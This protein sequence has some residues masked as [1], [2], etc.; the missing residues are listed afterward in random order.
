MAKSIHDE[1]EDSRR[2]AEQLAQVL[3]DHPTAEFIGLHG[4]RLLVASSVDPTHV[5]L[6]TANGPAQLLAYAE[7]HGIRVFYLKDRNAT[8]GAPRVMERLRLLNPDAY[9]A[10]VAAVNANEPSE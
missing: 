4:R 6:I 5:E 8:H 3:A 2:N 10:L 9:A 1:I 7:V